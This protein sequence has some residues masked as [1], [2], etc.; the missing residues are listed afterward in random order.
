MKEKRHRRS[1]QECQF[2]T[3]YIGEKIEENKLSENTDNL[4]KL[5]GKIVLKLY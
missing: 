3:K 4:P 2:L 1:I 5:K